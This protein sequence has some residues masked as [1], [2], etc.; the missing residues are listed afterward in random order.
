MSSS[1]LSRIFSVL[2]WHCWTLDWDSH[3]D[4]TRPHR[5]L[6]LTDFRIGWT[7]IFRFRVVVPQHADLPACL[8]MSYVDSVSS[9]LL[10]LWLLWMLPPLEPVLVSSAFRLHLQRFVVKVSVRPALLP[11]STEVAPVLAPLLVDRLSFLW[12]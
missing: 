12:L 3:R 7:T 10:A 9:V 5:T 8:A 2:R 11:V 1:D 4:L 6:L